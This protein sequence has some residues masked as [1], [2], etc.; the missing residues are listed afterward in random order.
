MYVSHP[1]SLCGVQELSAAKAYEIL[2]RIS[3]EDCEVRELGSLQR[4][5]G[6]VFILLRDQATLW[7]RMGAGSLCCAFISSAN[8]GSNKFP[9]EVGKVSFG[10]T[11]CV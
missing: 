1:T 11:S 3:D 9:L 10:A 6:R 5:A 8:S 4:E 2:K 7:L